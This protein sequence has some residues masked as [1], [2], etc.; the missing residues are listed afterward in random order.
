MQNYENL[1]IERKCPYFGPSP[2]YSNCVLFYLFAQH[3]FSIISQTVTQEMVKIVDDSMKIE[4]DR[5]QF[6]F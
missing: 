3:W 5:F 4:N 1:H 6:S 2:K